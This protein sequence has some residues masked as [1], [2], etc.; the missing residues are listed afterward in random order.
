MK[1][2]AAAFILASTLTVPAMAELP[3]EDIGD[4]TQF[5]RAAHQHLVWV[6][7]FAVPYAAEGRSYL[8]DADSGD[9]I[10]MINNGFWFNGLTL[11][12]TRNEIL[13]TET[14]FSRTTRGERTDIVVSYDAE[15]FMPTREITIPPK[16]ASMVKMQGQ[17][18]L[19]DDERFYGQIN[20]TPAQSLSIVDLET[21]AFTAEIDTPGCMNVYAGGNRQFHMLCGDGSFMT[22]T[23]DDQGALASKTRSA[24]LF[25]PFE[26]PI[27]ISGARDGAHWYFVS[28]AGQI[29]KFTMG[30]D[31]VV[32]A[33]QWDAIS[34]DERADEWLISGFQHLAVHGASNRLYLLTHQGT[35]ETFEDPG[36]EVWV[37]DADTHQRLDEI[38]LENR[39]ISIAVSQ[40]DDPLLYV[41]GATIPMPFLAQIWVYFTQGEAA[42]LNIIKFQL[43][44][45]SADDGA[46]QRSI[47]EVGSLPFH[48]QAW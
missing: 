12:D 5:D 39:A 13:A 22:L 17:H 15:T 14:H 7:D 41:S 16:R 48:L 31:G 8:F 6:T 28:F 38:S 44:V 40:D 24:P 43:D 42:F 29:F 21:G 23:V 10:S 30:A 27:T 46:Y 36:T 18:A 19:T 45:Y 25:E 32:L 11:P 4:H 34:E 35:P 26:D 9:M 37:F 2:I 1:K 20:F 3:P 33:D 47:G